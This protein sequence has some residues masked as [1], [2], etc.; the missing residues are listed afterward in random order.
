MYKYKRQHLLLIMRSLGFPILLFISLLVLPTSY[1]LAQT[2]V[3]QKRHEFGAC[4]AVF[5]IA[6]GDALSST[7]EP[8]FGGR[9]YY[10]TKWFQEPW[11]IYTG[12]SIGYVSLASRRVEDLEFVP[13]YFTLGYRLPFQSKLDVIPKF[14]IGA[15]YAE[16]QPNGITGWSPNFLLGVEFSVLVTHLFRV[17]A[18]FNSHIVYEKDLA[19]PKDLSVKPSVGDWVDMR[20]Q[21]PP[22]FQRQNTYLLQFGIFLGL[23]L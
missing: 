4:L 19:A 22:E 17:G 14:G 2:I 1:L 5:A 21:S 18:Y 11:S 12:V 7:L 23:N 6:P 10:R 9:F 20:F 15:S 3:T 16:I 13:L 8:Q